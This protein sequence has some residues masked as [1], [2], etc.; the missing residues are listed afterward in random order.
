MNAHSSARHLITAI[1]T[2]VFAQITCAAEVF[3]VVVKRVLDG[4]T[5]EIVN[6]KQHVRLANIDAPEASHGH[7]KPGQPFSQASTQHLEDLLL[8]IPITMACYDEDRYQRPVC[9]LFASGQ[10]VNKRMVIDGMAWANTSAHGRYLRDPSLID[11]QRNA[12]ALKKGIWSQPAIE[13]W[14][15]RSDCWK[16]K[17]CASLE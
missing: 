1:S 5:V 10:S 7:G 8:R 15:W 16:N 4:D 6:M 13:P 9:E 3:P 12:A 2:L 11:S 14:N 17:V